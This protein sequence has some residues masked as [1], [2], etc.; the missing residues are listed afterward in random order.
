M[1]IA[2][3]RAPAVAGQFYP[4]NP[5]ALR[6]VVGGQLAN[7]SHVQPAPERTAAIIA[8]HA[9]VVYSGQAAAHAYRRISGDYVK[10]VVLIG[11]SH[12]FRFERAA[13]VA[14][15]SFDT[16]LGE[17]PIDSDL[18]GRLS[19]Y[20]TKNVPTA[21]I[22][23]HS[24][25]LQLPFLAQAVGLVPIVPV[26]FGSKWSETHAKFAVT[27]AQ[28]L[29]PGDLV[30]AS[31]DLS[32]YLTNAQAQRQDSRSLDIL[33][34]Q[35]IEEVIAASNDGRFSMCGVTGVAVTMAYALAKGATEW[36]LLDQRTS[37]EASGDYSRVVGYAAVSLEYPE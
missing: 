16:P 8:P 26:L 11:C 21:H 24:L 17:F 7:A 5:D 6:K 30:V 18:A 28:I 31:T 23:E 10:R 20:S 4:S 36:T 19:A 22:E 3:K 29:G 32:H 25:E 35:D 37:A 2:L 1:N 34:A 15:G 9:G 33:L 27:L 12:R 14:E 13:I